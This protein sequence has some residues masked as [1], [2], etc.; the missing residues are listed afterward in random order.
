MK[1][2]RRIIK[3]TIWTV[4]AAYVSAVL[5]VHVPAVQAWIGRQAAGALADKLGTKV[6]VG[7]VYL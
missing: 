1:T 2:L 3:I 7:R 6:T 5:I 4:I